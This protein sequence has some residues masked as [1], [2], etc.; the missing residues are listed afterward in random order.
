MAEGAVFIT[1]ATGLLGTEVVSR[2]LTT[3]DRDIYAL[4]RA[5]SET[6]AASRLRSLWWDDAVLADAVGKRIHAVVGD[7]TKPLDVTLPANITHVIHCAAETGLQKSREHLWNINVEGTRRMVSLAEKLPRLQ[8]FTYVSTAYVCGTQHGRIMEDAPLTDSF[9]SLYEQSKASAEAIFRD[10]TLPYIVCRP[11]MIVGNSQTGR[12]RNFNTVYYVLK[13]MLQGK[14]HVVPVSSRQRVNVIPVDYVAQQVADLTMKPSAAGKTYHLT[15]PAD[16]LPQVGELVAAVCLWA[17]EHLNTDISKPLCIPL[18]MLRTI[19]K[20]YNAGREAKSRSLLSNL[21]AL[22]PYF[23]DDHVFDRTNTEQH[24]GPYTL[25]WRTFLPTLLAYAC[26][27][28]FM[29]LSDQTVFQQAVKRRESRHYPITYYD[30]GAQGTKR[31]TGQE[32]NAIVGHYVEQLQAL[33]VKVGERVAI[34]GINCA[35]HAAI[36]NAIGLLGAISVPIYYTTPADEIELLISKSGARWFFVGD[37]RVMK[38]V[39]ALSSDVQV[40]PFGPLSPSRGGGISRGRAMATPTAMPQTTYSGELATIRYTSG[41][42]GEPKGVMFNYSQLKW[43]GQVLTNLLSWRDRN[44][45]MRYLSFLPM[46]H[47]VEG[48]LAAYAPYCMLCRA[49]VYYLTDFQLLTHALPQVRP[50]VFFSVPRFYEKLWEQI[51]QN[52]IGRRYLKMQDGWLK[53]LTGGLL[54]RAVLRK[55]GLDKCSQLL[56]GSAPISEELL[57]RFRSLGIE[58][59][60]AYG[61]TEAP[62]ITL[63]RLGHNVIPSI[64]TALP[65]T[66]ITTA[67]DGELLVKGPQV[68]MGYYQIQTDTFRD[69]C[70]HTGDLGNI[71]NEGN[72]FIS[73]RKKDILITSYGKNINCTK[74][75]QRLMDI[76][77]V[78]QAV[79]VG[80][81][82]PYCTALLW[83]N[84]T[85]DNLAADIEHMN[86]Q[87]SHPEQ[88]KHYSII[89]TPLSIGRG[90]LTP[91]LKVKRNVVLEH[92]KHEI[93]KLYR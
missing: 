59:H 84:G 13:L 48:I 82:R 1:G 5:N 24:T 78:E 20:H 47:V 73:G 11:G 56:V 85:T 76:P 28:N 83:V 29:R 58:I 74:I 18:P 35:E 14:L 25:D 17:K 64:G 66:T 9:Y 72:V 49:K 67:P 60:N 32:M 33:G 40:I 43:M 62:L 70:L 54:R 75:E 92:Y 10:S 42:T 79:L 26:R 23:L 3:T 6:E 63:N 4:V 50:T 65:D 27:Q 69:D 77:C 91:N 19:G 45:E 16:R 46:S 39:E 7:I 22:M 55:A 57:H 61:Q 71:D 88:V 30:I 89:D 53:R 93:E 87:L 68:G 36:D 52:A 31:I 81:Q 80:E 15:A 34:S 12:T 38:N 86:A 90:E 44:S 21:T 37:E 51:E 41:T 2:L 8:R